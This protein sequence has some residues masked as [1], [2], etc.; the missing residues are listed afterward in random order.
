MRIFK[1]KETTDKSSQEKGYAC[2]GSIIAKK[3]VLNVLK[4]TIPRIKELIDDG[5]NK[6][7]DD[8]KKEIITLEKRVESL[9]NILMVRD[10]TNKK[11]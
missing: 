8:L 1:R 6:T 4:Q 7:K 11:K 9:E 3:I 10:T 5:D 2:C